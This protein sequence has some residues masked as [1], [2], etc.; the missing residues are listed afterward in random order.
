MYEL[1]FIAMVDFGLWLALSREKEVY[2]VVVVVVSRVLCRCIVSLPH[3]YVVEST[4]I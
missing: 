1:Y 4:K 2:V 3:I